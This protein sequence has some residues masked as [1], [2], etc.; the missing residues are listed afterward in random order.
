MMR[1]GNRLL[2]SLSGREGE[3]SLDFDRFFSLMPVQEADE[4]DDF[5]EWLGGRLGD[6]VVDDDEGNSWDVE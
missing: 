5:G 4:N 3:I 1:Q 6:D 2:A